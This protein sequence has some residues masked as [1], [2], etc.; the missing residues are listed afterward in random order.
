MPLV[1]RFPSYLLTIRQIAGLLMRQR[2]NAL[3]FPFNHDSTLGWCLDA[4]AARLN[5]SC[6][7]NCAVVRGGTSASNPSSTGASGSREATDSPISISKS[8]GSNGTLEVRT[9]APVDCGDELTISY[10]DLTDPAYGGRA[11]GSR[12]SDEQAARSAYIEEATAARRAAL[13]EKYL[14]WCRCSRCTRES[15]PNSDAPPGAASSDSTASDGAADA[16]RENG[17]GATASEGGSGA[18]TTAANNNARQ[19]A[20]VVPEGADPGDELRV[21]VSDAADGDSA[22]TR[23]LRVPVPTGAVPGTKLV[24]TY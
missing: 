16:V 5:H 8:T 20:V 21:E 4:S 6:S 18:A 22:Q 12:N 11:E 15:A 7:P 24:V 10:L 19:V 1:H 2:V 14:F 13:H 9:I 23:V 17:A 3:G